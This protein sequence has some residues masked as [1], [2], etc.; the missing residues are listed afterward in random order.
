V[1]REW[2]Q[3]DVGTNML[4]DA[5]LRSGQRHLQGEGVHAESARLRRPNQADLQRRRFRLRRCS[6]RHRLLPQFCNAATCVDYLFHD[7][8]EDGDLLGWTSGAGTYTS[9]MVTV[10]GAA[11]TTNSA[12]LAKNGTSFSYTDGIYQA[13]GSP[14]APTTISWY[15]R[16]PSAPSEYAG[17]V[18]LFSSASTTNLLARVYFSYTGNIYLADLNPATLQKIYSINTWYHFEFKNIN[19]VNRTFDFYIDGTPVRTTEYF[20][21]TGNGVGRIDLGDY[22]S[23]DS[24][25]FDQIDFLP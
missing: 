24:A 2:R 6:C 7:D 18:S 3:L 12:Y 9:R 25:Y 17:I 23:A 11:G 4:D 5:V 1:Q 15:A 22:Y 14:L 10:P 19:W 16:I 8:F 13:F 20:G 21:S